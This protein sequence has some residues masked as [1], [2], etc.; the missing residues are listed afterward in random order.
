[1]YKLCSPDSARDLEISRCYLRGWDQGP[2]CR[3]LFRH[4]WP[5]HKSPDIVIN[6][7]KS[8]IVMIFTWHHFHGSFCSTPMPVASSNAKYVLTNK[9]RVLGVL[10]NERRVSLPAHPA[11]VLEVAAEES[12]HLHVVRAVQGGDHQYSPG[13]H[14][15]GTQ[16]AGQW[17]M[18]IEN[19]DQWHESF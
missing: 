2:Q 14:P 3:Q 16:E 18:S 17:K 13:L 12:D 15:P 8:W 6:H 19:I 4:P 5:S 9:R 7:T 11:P 10:T 1:M